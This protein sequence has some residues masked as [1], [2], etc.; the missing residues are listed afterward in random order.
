MLTPFYSKLRM[1]IVKEYGLSLILMQMFRIVLSIMLCHQGYRVYI[2]Q[3]TIYRWVLTFDD[4]VPIIFTVGCILLINS[5]H[6]KKVD[7]ISFYINKNFSSKLIEKLISEIT[8]SLT[9]YR[10]FSRWMTGIVITVSVLV[11]GN[12]IN[13]VQKIFDIWYSN[14]NDIEK[15]SLKVVIDSI[16]IN[17]SNYIIQVLFT[18]I[19]NLVVAAIGIY[20]LLQTITYFRR[21]VLLILTNSLYYPVDQRRKFLDVVIEPTKEVYK[22]IVDSVN[23]DTEL[24]NLSEKYQDFKK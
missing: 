23:I 11:F 7:N 12:S 18:I 13:I 19:F 15:K 22:F 16:S 1:I 6:K 17:E 14:L 5:S 24:R 2:Q 10:E 20:F 8:N 3:T 21:L 4:V 9:Q